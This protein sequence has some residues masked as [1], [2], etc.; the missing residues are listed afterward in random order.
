MEVDKGAKILMEKW[1]LETKSSYKRRFLS[2]LSC[3]FLLTVNLRHYN[4]CLRE[5]K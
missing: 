2:K 4:N 1:R 3:Y 5:N